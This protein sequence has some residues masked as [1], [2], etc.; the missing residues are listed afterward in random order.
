MEDTGLVEVNSPSSMLLDQY[1]DASG[2]AVTAVVEGSRIFLHEIQA[3]VGSTPYPNPRRVVLGL[4]YNRLLQ[5]VAVLE[6]K[7]GL[8][9]SK[10]DVYVNVVGGLD[11]IEPGYD[12]ALCL[13]IIS[14]IRDIP[15]SNKTIIIGEI[16]LLGEVRPV[17]NIERRLKEACKLGF[18][19]AIIPC[20]NSETYKKINSIGL[21][22]KQVK[23]VTDAI[24][25]GL[26]QDKS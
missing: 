18:R 24:I 14:S 23:K 2:C 26:K 20:V 1:E 10:Q 19:K 17:A 13:A 12:L 21:E 3:L 11:I 16:G 5:I 7:V 4:D 15:I 9:L 6:K 25:Q 8:N 22:L